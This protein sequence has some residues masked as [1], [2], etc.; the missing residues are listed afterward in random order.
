[1]KV[2]TQWVNS[3]IG[4][5]Y[6]PS[7]QMKAIAGGPGCPTAPV[8]VYLQSGWIVS[9]SAIPPGGYGSSSFQF[10]AP[11]TKYTTVKCTMQLTTSGV[12]FGTPYTIT[13]ITQ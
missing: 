13:F 7:I 9:R 4:T 10:K 1:M 6:Q 2:T 5:W 12:P 8:P 11:T 3:G